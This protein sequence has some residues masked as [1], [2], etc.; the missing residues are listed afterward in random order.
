MPE[1][2]VAANGI[3]IWTEDFGS[4]ADPALLLIMGASAQ[5][6]AW[7][8]ELCAELAAGGR[9]VI[10]Y[11][12]RDTG[13]STCFDFSEHPYSCADMAR[14]AVGV[15]DAYGIAR[16]HVA[17]ASM[18]GIIGQ[19]LALEHAGRLRTLTAI[20]STPGGA[21]VASAIERGEGVSSLPP[22][23]PA[24]IERMLAAAQSPPRT[25]EERIGQQVALF[26]VLSGSLG[27]Y[28]EARVRE[29]AARSIDRARNPDA[30]ANHTLAVGA[31]PDRLDALGS[32]E[33]P[34]LVIHG[35]EDPI[36]PY[37]HGVALAKGIPGAELL[38][39]EGMGHDLPPAA[40]PRIV[41][42]ILQ[43]TA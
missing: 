6:I 41:G 9:H 31:T 12:N 19:I 18:G 7:P 3:E 21:S 40:W 28:D 8:D 29:L 34:T 27:E 26:Q 2:T 24:V 11:D 13:L 43:H 5:G 42:A 23:A 17:G 4:A 38:T 35:T 14:D 32:I 30:A 33:V 37:D 16:A 25:R 1:R 10:R 39:I 22:P 15:L 20:M 36:L